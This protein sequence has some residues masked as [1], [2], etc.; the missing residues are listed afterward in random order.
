MFFIKKNKLSIFF[1]L[2]KFAKSDDVIAC[3]SPEVTVTELS[4]KII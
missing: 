3:E 4:D 1:N 2:K